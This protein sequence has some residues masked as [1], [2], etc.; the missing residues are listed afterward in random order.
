MAALLLR[1]CVNKDRLWDFKRPSLLPEGT[2][3]REHWRHMTQTGFGVPGEPAGIASSVVYHDIGHVLA[4]PE[5]T[6][7]GE[8]QQGAFQGGNRR[9]DGF[10]FIQF[11]VLQFHQGMKVAPATA[12]RSATSISRTSGTAGRLL[13]QVGT[14]PAVCAMDGL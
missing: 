13:G 10:F 11:V 7:L 9:D 8:I 2:L 5:T 6:P 14:T 4:A 3:G 1:L 12:A